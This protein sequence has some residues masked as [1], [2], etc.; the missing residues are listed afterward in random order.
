[1]NIKR[2]NGTAWVN[3]SA[4]KRW[5]GT[6]WLNVSAVKRWNGTAWVDIPLGPN[7]PLPPP[8][9]N[10]ILP[11]MFNT[12]PVILDI[13]PNPTNDYPVG[14]ITYGWTWTNKAPETL[15]YTSSTNITTGLVHCHFGATCHPFDVL[16]YARAMG[17]DGNWV[18]SNAVTVTGYRFD[19]NVGGGGGGF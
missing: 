1:M 12:T 10:L 17:R 14:A 15:T 5:D 13:T 4:V 3:V 6:A 18:Y 2:W 19:D 9:V 7:P 8:G 16:V 11:S